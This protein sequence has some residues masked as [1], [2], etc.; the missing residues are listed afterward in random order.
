MWLL[1]KSWHFYQQLILCR[2]YFFL[3]PT[4]KRFL[5]LYR[6]PLNQFSKHP[7]CVNCPGMLWLETM[8]ILGMCL[9]R[10]LI[11]KSPSAGKAGVW[12]RMEGNVVT[13]YAGLGEERNNVQEVPLHCREYPL[14]EYSHW[15]HGT[16]EE[17]IGANPT[18]CR[19]L[20]TAS[21][22]DGCL[23]STWAQSLLAGNHISRTLILM[24]NCTYY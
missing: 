3:F 20:L 6:K 16:L 13:G 19:Q 4:N 2:K 17:A 7:H 12:Q 23:I 21:Q 8:I 1:E 14:L 5:F 22:A 18:W 11:A 24:L 10:L 15:N 9:P